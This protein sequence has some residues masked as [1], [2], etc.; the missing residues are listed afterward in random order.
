M[1]QIKNNNKNR[2]WFD[3]YKPIYRSRCWS[4]VI[5]IIMVASTI[6]LP[7]TTGIYVTNRILQ[8]ADCRKE[9]CHK[10]QWDKAVRF[11]IVDLLSASLFQMN[12]SIGILISTIIANIVITYIC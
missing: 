1:C 7:S 4:M 6:F 8:T 11:N 5:I 12:Q 2:Y 3:R 9:G 10:H